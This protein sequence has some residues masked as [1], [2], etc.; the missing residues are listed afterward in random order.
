MFERYTQK[1][2]RVL[3]SSRAEAQIAG[4]KSIESEHLLL[5]L[6][7]E[8]SDLFAAITNLNLT[9]EALRQRIEAAHPAGNSLPRDTDL[10]FSDEC[11]CILFY[12]AEESRR[13]GDKH[14]GTEHLMLGMLCEDGSL[15]AKLLRQH[16]ADPRAIRKTFATGE[17]TH[18]R[19][20]G[21]GPR[22]LRSLLD[23]TREKLASLRVSPAPGRLRP[24][25]I[26]FHK[27]SEKARRVILFARYEARNLGASAIEPEHMLLGITHEMSYS[28]LQNVAEAIRKSARDSSETTAES[29]LPLSERT[30]QVLAT[31]RNEATRREVERIRPEHILFGIASE[32]ESPAARILHD[33]G[34]DAAQICQAIEDAASRPDPLQT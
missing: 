8:D 3:F 10:R 21:L 28:A 9:E 30:K 14:I 31:A 2:R 1:A 26:E 4:S 24:A 12:A 15:A 33:H 18:P 16:G 11:K 32:A 5:G 23:L 19:Q 25:G 13:L 29:D 22:R 27:F 7:R 17:P 20:S 34:V 6:L